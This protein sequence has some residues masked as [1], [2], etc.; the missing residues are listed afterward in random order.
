MNRHEFDKLQNIVIKTAKAVYD[1]EKFPVAFLAA[2]A[3]RIA[4]QFPHDPTSVAFSGFLTKRA[5][6]NGSLFITRAELKDVY[7]KLYYPNNKLAQHFTNE[8]GIVE[9]TN[10]TFTGRKMHF[11]KRTILTIPIIY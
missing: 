2:R 8:L 10:T 5:S 9:R 7:N 6:S 3:S 1:N 4:Q 11:L